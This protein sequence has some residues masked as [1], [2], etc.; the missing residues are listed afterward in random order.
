MKSSCP[1]SPPRQEIGEP[2]DAR[3]F[4]LL[5]LFLSDANH[6]HERA[7]ARRCLADAGSAS[8]FRAT[9][10]TTWGERLYDDDYVNQLAN[11]RRMMIPKRI[12][13]RR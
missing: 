9:S 11:D 13:A 4:Q 6:D 2:Q 7:S 1:A 8:R 5:G 12:R 3:F 10:P